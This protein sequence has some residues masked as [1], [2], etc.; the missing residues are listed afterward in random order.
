[1]WLA[2]RAAY[3]S[4][5]RRQC[6]SARAVRTEEGTGEASGGVVGVAAAKISRST[7]EGRQRRAGSPSGGR[8]RDRGG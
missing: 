2:R 7:I 5:A 3:S 4:I 8:A 6:G 1:V